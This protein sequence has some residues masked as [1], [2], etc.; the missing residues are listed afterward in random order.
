MR[1][2]D[3]FHHAT[4]YTRDCFNPHGIKPLDVIVECTMREPGFASYDLT[5]IKHLDADW[6]APY[7][8]AHGAVID[9]QRFFNLELA[10]RAAL[11][12][13]QSNR[14]PAARRA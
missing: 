6:D 5:L 2:I 9:P 13:Y 10:A 8:F 7:S 11:A 3:R 12:W 14:Q 1:A 4:E